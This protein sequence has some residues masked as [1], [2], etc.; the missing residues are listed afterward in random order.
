MTLSEI[1][2]VGT[3]GSFVRF[4]PPDLVVGVYAGV[5]SV[6]DQ[7]EMFEHLRRFSE[8]KKFVLTM[9]D[10]GRAQPFSAETRKET[11]EVGKNLP[12]RGTAVIGASFQMRALAS[13]MT[14]VINLFSS[15]ADRD[16][17]MAFFAT[18]AQARAWLSERRAVL[19]REAR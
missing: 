6:T 14:K 1:R 4:E 2:H 12:V 16:S 15:R 18:E 3:Q 10:L 17:P 7:R 9:I 19:Q 11:A 5:V 13:L 8:G